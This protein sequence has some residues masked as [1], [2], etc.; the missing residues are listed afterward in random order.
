MVL[1]FMD[2]RNAYTHYI[3]D[4]NSRNRDGRVGCKARGKIAG[5][6]GRNGVGSRLSN[7]AGCDSIAR[8]SASLKAVAG[9]VGRLALDDSLSGGGPQTDVLQGHLLARSVVGADELDRWTSN[10]VSD[11]TIPALEKHM[12]NYQ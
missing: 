9:T 3:A 6:G 12:L 11:V 2:V 5:Q 10:T 8:R 7:A 1:F 4:V